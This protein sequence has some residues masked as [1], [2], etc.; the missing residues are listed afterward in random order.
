[1]VYRTRGAVELTLTF[2]KAWARQ[3]DYIELP[4]MLPRIR[5]NLAAM[6]EGKMQQ[7]MGR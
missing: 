6:P 2:R 5:V 1:M 4:R 7:T 3:L